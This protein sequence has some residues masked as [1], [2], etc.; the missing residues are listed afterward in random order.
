MTPAVGSHQFMHA[1]HSFRPGPRKV[2]AIVGAVA[3]GAVLVSGCSNG[4]LVVSPS[5]EPS[6]PQ[7]GS[8]VAT[9]GL[10][11]RHSAE[12]DVVNGATSVSVSTARLGSELLRVSTPPDSGIRPDL[13]IGNSVQLY[14]DSAGGNGPAAVQVVL[15]SAVSWRLLFA[16]GANQTSADLSG[17]RFAGA[18]FA[19]GSSLI[20]LTLPR[21][22]GTTTVQLAGGASQVS[23]GLPTG[24]PAQ[25]R[26]LGGASSATLLGH[27]YTGIAGGTVLTS[28]GWSRARARYLID[29]PAGVS[30]ID[31]TG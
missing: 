26:L 24:V 12:L 28:P 14:L 15:N 22:A 17:G 29:A 8:H 21:P 2:R 18:D 9:A 11:L 30:A 1:R 5:P 3:L 10:G 27:T 20:A 31:V 23:V 19:A 6:S 25:L 13:V 16:G 7:P 4:P